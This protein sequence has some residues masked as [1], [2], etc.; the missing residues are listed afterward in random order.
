MRV[1]LISNDATR[2]ATGEC[3]EAHDLAVSKLIAGRDKDI[4]FVA[5]LLRHQLAMASLIEQRLADTLLRDESLRSFLTPRL[6]QA[7]SNKPA[8]Q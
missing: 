5:A 2:G 1:V 4:D 6:R 3:L 7:A 8:N